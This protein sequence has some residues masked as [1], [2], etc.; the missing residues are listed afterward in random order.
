MIAGLVRLFSR[1]LVE[2]ATALRPPPTARLTI[3]PFSASLRQAGDGT[4]RDWLRARLV[5][6]DSSDRAKEGCTHAGL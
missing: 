6:D 4:T 1:C 2:S 3:H 5:S